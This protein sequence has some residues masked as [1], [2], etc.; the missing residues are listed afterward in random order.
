MG[1]KVAVATLR[2]GS[3]GLLFQCN[4]GDEQIS[5]VIPPQTLRD[6]VEFNDFSEMDESAFRALLPQIERIVTAKYEIG[7][8][9]EDGA[10]SICTADILRYGLRKRDRSPA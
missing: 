1:L 7:R 9:E 4:N 6:L 10:L 3:Q 8:I 2:A 5:C